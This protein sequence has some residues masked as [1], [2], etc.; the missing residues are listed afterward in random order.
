MLLEL[1]LLLLDAASI[2]LF[3]LSHPSPFLRVQSALHLSSSLVLLFTP[4]FQSLSMTTQIPPPPLTSLSSVRVSPRASRPAATTHDLLILL[5]ATGLPTLSQ[6]EYA[7]H[8]SPICSHAQS[9]TSTIHTQRGSQHAGEGPTMHSEVHN[10][11][12][13]FSEAWVHST[14]IKPHLFS[15]VRRD[16]YL[17]L[18]WNIS[19]RSVEYKSFTFGCQNYCYDRRLDDLWCFQC[20]CISLE[21][22]R[23]QNCPI[24]MINETKIFRPHNIYST[25]TNINTKT[26]T[27][28]K[29]KGQT[30]T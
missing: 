10:S 23:T 28:T 5:A 1:P 4:Q 29:T 20:L 8:S 18:T 22:V 14:K 9:H 27:K 21:L 15:A 11:I 12:L 6:H 2:T 7:K 13:T 19:E 16:V 26:K 24:L 30:K 17:A 25:L 3:L